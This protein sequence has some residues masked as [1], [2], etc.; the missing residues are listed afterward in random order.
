MQQFIGIIW[1]IFKQSPTV[2]TALVLITHSAMATE[3]NVK[4]LTNHQ[5]TNDQSITPDISLPLTI[6]EVD[7]NME[8]PAVSSFSEEDSME[9]VTSVSQLSDVQP[10]DWAFQALQSLVERYGCIAGYPDGTYKGNRAMT[11]YE[12]AAGMNACLDRITELISTSTA[13]LVTREDLLTLQKLQEEFAAELATMRGQIDVLEARTA[14]LENKQFSTTTKLMGVATMYFAGAAGDQTAESLIITDQG[15]NTLR[16][17]VDVKSQPVV[18]YSTLLSFVS[19]F[20]GQDMLTVDLWASNLTPFSGPLFGFTENVTGTYMSRLSFDAP[21]YNNS[22]ALADLT[23][24]F[25][26]AKNLSV[27]IDAVGGEVSGELLTSTQPFAIFAPYTVSISRFGRFDPIYYQTLARPGIAANYSFT[28]NL[29]L[30]LGYFGDF[31]S[32]NPKT[33]IFGGGNAS[34]AQLAYFPTDTLGITLAYVHSYNPAGPGVSVSGQTGS[35]YADQP[36]GSFMADAPNNPLDEKTPV[37]IATSA[38]HFALGFGWR[39][40]PK[41]ALTGDVGFA[42]AH[43]LQDNPAYQVEQGDNATL[44]EWNLGVSLLDLFGAGNVGSFLVGN[45][46]RVIS[47]DSEGLSP[48]NDTAWHFEATYKYS[49]NNNISLQPGFL[50]I[51]NPEN[52]ANNDPIWLWQLKTSFFF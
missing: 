13:D 52:N 19:S 41:F 42:I 30:G 48:E 4:E 9:Q 31:D 3:V 16:P 20:T 40:S 27:F 8:I 45:P 35:L 7:E 12:F 21:P 28:D 24:K 1:H 26:P 32:A 34:I 23:Y 5:L 46:Y 2:L 47:H 15:A 50:V 22:V 25:Q 36:F 11:R 49:I 43:A 29:S 37:S 10:T 33:G 14:E 39:A 44:F 38:D 51:V 6:A 17:S 18:Q